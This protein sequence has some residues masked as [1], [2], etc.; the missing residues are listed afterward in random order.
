MAWKHK[1]LRNTN[2]I[3]C[4]TVFEIGDDGTLSPEPEGEALEVIVFLPEFERVVE[5]PKKVA[6]KSSPE[7]KKAEAPPEKKVSPKKSK[8]SSKKKG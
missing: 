8:S 5:P 7:P 4:S 2:C 1:T 3:A 6:S